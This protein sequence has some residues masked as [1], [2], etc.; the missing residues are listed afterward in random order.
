MTPFPA[1]PQGGRSRRIP[2]MN[3]YKHI[4]ESIHNHGADLNIKNKAREL[5]KRMTSSEIILW[6]AIRKGQLNGMYFRRQHPYGIYIL[7]FYCFK[8]N[9]AIEIDGKIHLGKKKY[10]LQRMEYLESSG[11]K[12]LRFLNTDIE[13]RIDWVVEQ[14]K[15]NRI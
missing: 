9:L 10:D 6:N 5:R 1:F 14:I 4:N 7:D 2:V 13:T 15:L 11:L 8:S 12:V 3:D